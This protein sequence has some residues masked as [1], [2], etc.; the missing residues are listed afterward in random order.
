MGFDA[1]YRSLVSGVKFFVHVLHPYYRMVVKADA[2]FSCRTSEIESR[3]TRSRVASDVNPE[4][5]D[6]VDRD[7]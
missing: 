6:A 1:E 2:P 3:R 4:V 5:S 7:V